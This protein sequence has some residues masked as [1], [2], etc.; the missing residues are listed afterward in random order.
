MLDACSCHFK[1][2]ACPNWNRAWG[3]GGTL[4]LRNEFK[5]SISLKLAKMYIF[6]SCHAEWGCPDAHKGNWPNSDCSSDSPYEERQH[7]HEEKLQN[8]SLEDRLAWSSLSIGGKIHWTWWNLSRLGGLLGWMDWPWT[9]ITWAQSFPSIS[10]HILRRNP[11]YIKQVWGNGQ[12]LY[13]SLHQ[14]L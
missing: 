10:R 14:E 8:W 6:S 13:H 3:I 7:K 1:R 9:E 2:K 11:A 4:G 5:F 12:I